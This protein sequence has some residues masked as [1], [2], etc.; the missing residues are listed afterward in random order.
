MN[1]LQKELDE[2]FRLISAI[3][4]SG[5]SVEVMAWPGSGCGGPISRWAGRRRRTNMADRR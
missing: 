3:P 2:V 4:V 5:E 1:E